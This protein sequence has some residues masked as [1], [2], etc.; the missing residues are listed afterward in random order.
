MIDIRPMCVDD[1]DAVF[2][3]Q[4]EA[5]ADGFIESR[6][7]IGERL[8]AA[9]QTAW[10]AEADGQVGAYLVA[11]PSVRGRLSALGAG[12]QPSAEADSLY[13]H[14]LAVQRRLAGQGVGPALV[15]HAWAQALRLGLV[16]SSLVS[17]QSS[18]AFWEGLGYCPQAPRV[19]DQDKLGSY[20]GPACYMLARLATAGACVS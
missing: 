20:P 1:I 12:F 2:G 13:I 15:R 17:V 4:A 8:A 16:Y 10:V 3:V 18:M 7:V 9:P 6:T 14:D 19:D 11:Y 5:Y